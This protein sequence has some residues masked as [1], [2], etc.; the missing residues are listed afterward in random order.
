MKC[1]K[2]GYVSHDYLDACRKCSIDLVA[3]KHEISLA[4]LEPGLLDLIALVNGNGASSVNGNSDEYD[5]SSSFLGSSMLVETETPESDE[6]EEVD[7]RLDDDVVNAMPSTNQAPG[8][9]T[10]EFFVPDELLAD[11]FKE[12]DDHDATTDTLATGESD[13]GIRMAQDPVTEEILNLDFDDDTISNE[14][15]FTESVTDDSTD[16]IDMNALQELRDAS[17]EPEEVDVEAIEAA[18]EPDDL[19]AIQMDSAT[20]D[21]EDTLLEEDAAFPPSDQAGSQSNMIL[22]EFDKLDSMPLQDVAAEEVSDSEGAR[23]EDAIAEL[24]NASGS[25]ELPDDFQLDDFQV[26]DAQPEDHT[27]DQPQASGGIDLPDDFQ[28]GDSTP[29]EAVSPGQV[30]VPP[31]AAVEPD[32][33]PP[34]NAPLPEGE[35][36]IT[37]SLPIDPNTETLFFDQLSDASDLAGASGQETADHGTAAPYDHTDTPAV[38]G[39]EPPDTPISLD[40][41]SSELLTDDLLG[42]ESTLELNLE[43]EL[44]NSESLVE[45]DADE[46]PVDLE[47]PDVDEGTTQP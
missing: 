6:E 18:I 12:T 37:L 20:I 16:V 15:F 33:T 35:E 21:F 36:K 11:E 30:E 10:R 14:T 38:E 2:C 23:P 39:D 1:P 44:P 27:P 26:D 32:P 9:L 40:E 31:A 34:Q 29:A 46:A 13:A 5:K 3:F 7:I 28:L 19:S 24:P 41:L 42:A 4:V 25:L 47:K 8:S 43:L 17:N 45:D 22:D